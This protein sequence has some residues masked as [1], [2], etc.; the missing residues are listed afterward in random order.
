MALTVETG[1]G[2]ASS[3]SYISLADART[4]LT[5]RGL[6]LFATDDVAAEAALIKAMDYIEAFRDRF[7]GEKYTAAQALQWP[8]QYAYVDGFE[9]AVT[10]IPVELGYAQ[11]IL[12]YESQTYDLQATGDGRII[13][14][15]KVDE[16]ETTYSD[17]KS[18]IVQ[19]KFK[20]VDD[21]LKPL[22][23]SSGLEVIRV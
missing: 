18:S 16:I 7:K 17:T 10:A 4:Y 1:T 8:R 20:R 11:S 12:A 19:A 22:L 3:N 14:K 15:E 6:S 2:S 9:V 23:K 5:A 13:V 21:L